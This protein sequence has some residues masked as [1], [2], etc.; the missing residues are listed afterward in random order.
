MNTMGI[1]LRHHKEGDRVEVYE[2]PVTER[3]YEA[4]VTL[5]TRLDADQDYPFMEHWL[6]KFDDNQE[7]ARFIRGVDIA[8]G[9]FE[10]GAAHG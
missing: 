6:V 7:L 10:R 5:V 3:K 1:P 8:P 2:D 9:E 4:S